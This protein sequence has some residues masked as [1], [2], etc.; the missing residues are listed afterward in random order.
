MSELKNNFYYANQ[1]YNLLNNHYPNAKIVL[2]FSNNFQLLVAII[3]SA[4]TT[5]ITVNKVTETL[6]NKYRTVEDFANANLSELE[7]DISMVGL[8]RNKAKNIIATA[9]I[10]TE[11]YN[12][13]IPNSISELIKLPGIGRKTANVFL[14]NA[15]NISEGIA[16]D[17]HVARLS[18]RLGF[19]K[20]KD[21]GKI[22][23][24][25]IKLFDKTKWFKLTYLLIEH[26][27]KICTAKDPRCDKCFLNKICPSAFM[28]PRFRKL[29]I[30]VGK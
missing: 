26:G 1:V 27:R 18:Q 12:D 5:D 23:Q 3:L 29:K 13:E 21:A 17:T 30:V 25:L 11:K 2:K 24:D 7:K 20:N 15:Y 19:A 10:I 14:G 4:Q 8:F 6:F 28:F 16:V 9:K 22:E